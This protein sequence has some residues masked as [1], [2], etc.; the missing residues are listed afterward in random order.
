MKGE[1]TQNG[2]QLVHRHGD[3]TLVVEPWGRD[4]LRVRASLSEVD[5]RNWALTETAAGALRESASTTIIEIADNQA[6]IANGLISARL[7]DP[8]PVPGSGHVLQAGHLQFFRAGEPI[9]GEYD[10]VVGAHNPGTRTYKP[11]PGFADEGLY[12]TEVHFAPRPD[13]RLYGMGLNATGGVNLKG[14]VI[15]L[16]QRH[17]KHTVP[18]LVSSAG[19]GL[20]WNNPSLGRV[21]LGR[22]RTRWVSEGCRQIDYYVT[23]G[24]TYD[25]IMENYADDHGHAPECRTGMVSGRCKLR[26]RQD[27]LRRPREFRRRGLPLWSHVIDFRHWRKTG[28]WKLDP[29]FWPDPEAMV[30][31]LDDMGVRIMISPWVLV[32]EESENFGPMLE[33]GLF[34]DAL[35]GSE[36]WIPWQAN[37]GRRFERARS[38]PQTPKRPPTCGTSGSGTTSTWGS[39]RSGWIPATTCIRFRTTTRCGTTR[40]RPWRP[41]AIT[42]WPTRRTSTTPCMPPANTRWSRFAAVRGPVRSATAPPRPHTT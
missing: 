28:D 2:C 33:R 31:E 17:V 10:Y 18:F 5:D 19:Y 6:S 29:D 40:G 34:I 14:C 32:E 3:E 8:S 13:E 23:V 15:D 36:T 24:D 4:G 12:R 11:V 25:A 1:L 26:Y 21:E 20:L 9:L 22:N 7:T 39:G 41:T 30:R 38:I 27:D 16:Y 42:R 35:D 37:D